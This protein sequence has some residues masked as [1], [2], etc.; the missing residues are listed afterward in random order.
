MGIVHQ[1]LSCEAHV[2][3]YKLLSYL[4]CGL[5]VFFIFDMLY[6]HLFYVRVVILIRRFLWVL[7]LRQ[8]F[9]WPTYYVSHKLVKLLS[10]ISLPICL[11]LAQ[12]SLYNKRNK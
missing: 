10:T 6:D 1:G 7:L 8:N 9:F 12:N 2:I 11:F 5:F 3:K 4:Y